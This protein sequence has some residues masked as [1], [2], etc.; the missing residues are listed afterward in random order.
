M[1]DWYSLTRKMFDESEDPY[2]T[3]KFTHRVYH[4]L[5]RMRLKDKGKFKN[6]MGPE[7]DGWTSSLVQEFPEV[8]IREVLNNDEFWNLSLSLLQGV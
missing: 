6:R 5:R 8:L 3:K 2:L 7:F 1:E 4:D